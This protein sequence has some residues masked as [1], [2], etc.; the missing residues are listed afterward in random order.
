MHTHEFYIDGRWVKPLS[1]ATLDVID[2][3]TEEACATIAIGSAE[4]ADRAVMAARRAFDRFTVSSVAERV[5]LLETILAIYKRR[6]QDMADA[7]RMEMGAP[8]KMALT[9]QA[10]SGEAHI[11]ATIKALRE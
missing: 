5:E 4:D 10:W 3:A 8:A 11:E 2:P 7:I 9:S 6:S 1:A